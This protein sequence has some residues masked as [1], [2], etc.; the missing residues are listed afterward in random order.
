MYCKRYC[1]D[2][3][4]VGIRRRTTLAAFL[5]VGQGLGT[6]GGPFFGGLLYKIGLKN[7]IFNGFTSPGWIMAGIWCIMWICVTL[8]FEDV[9]RDQPPLSSQTTS[10]SSQSTA[11][12]SAEEKT[13]KP[14]PNPPF[15]LCSTQKGVII[16]MCWWAMAAFFILGA[17]E[18]NIPV[19]G[20]AQFHWSPLDA[21]YF[22]A[23]GGAAAF[24]FLIMNMFAVRRFGDRNALAFGFGLGLSALC[25]FLALLKTGKLNYASMFVCWWAVAL[26]FNV[27]TTIPI[28]L[29]S[30]QLPSSWNNRISL[31]VQCSMYAGRVMGAIWGG[32][33]VRVGMLVYDGIQI[34]LVGVGIILY[35]ALWHGLE[36][37]RG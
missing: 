31:T 37:K 22:I 12:E 5:V 32:S 10:Q 3:R 8:W 35:I 36:A 26:G 7:P 2:P 33:A 24:P 17:W 20:A 29:L 19:F 14:G 18:A 25:I 4:I 23:L 9:P 30:K 34:T 27:V 16:C 15:T 11:N 1:S 6:S 28:S 13:E 21:G